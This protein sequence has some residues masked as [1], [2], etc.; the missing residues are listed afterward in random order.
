LGV[1][2]LVIGVVVGAALHLDAQ[3]LGIWWFGARWQPILGLSDR[4]VH[5]VGRLMVPRMLGLAAVQVNFWINTILASSLAPGSLSALNYGWLLMLLPQGIIAQG[6]ATAAFPT[7]ASLEA[8]GRFDDFKYTLTTTLRGVLFLTIPATVGLFIWRVPLIRMLLERG[9]FDTHSTQLTAY[10]LAFYSLGLVAHS[11]V[12]ILARAF[13]ALHDT[14][15]PV[16]VSVSAMGLNALLSLLLVGALSFGGLALANTVATSLE[17]VALFLLLTW[18]LHGLDWLAISSTIVRSAVAALV[19][20]LA[21]VW[22]FGQWGGGSIWVVGAGGL[23][24]GCLVYLACAALLR[25]PELR[26]LRLIGA[27]R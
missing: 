23:I 1:Y 2:G 3:L 27:R 13:Y 26:A 5:E 21:L 24:L 19:M 12:E 20:G 16:I 25:M 10:A 8:R 7:F 15:T 9:Q 11:M 6:V 18:R 4:H 17:M 14:R 22:V